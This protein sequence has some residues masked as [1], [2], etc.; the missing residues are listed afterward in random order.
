MTQMLDLLEN[1]AVAEPRPPQKSTLWL[2]DGPCKVF[3]PSDIS[4]CTCADMEKFAEHIS[5]D[6]RGLEMFNVTPKTVF[7][8]PEET[9]RALAHS[10]KGVLLGELRVCPVETGDVLRLKLDEDPGEADKLF[11]AGSLWNWFGHEG[12]A[13]AA[14]SSSELRTDKHKAIWL[15][16]IRDIREALSQAAKGAKRTRGGDH[17]SSLGERAQG[18]WRKGSLHLVEAAPKDEYK[19][20]MTIAPGLEVPEELRSRGAGVDFEYC[21][22]MLKWVGDRLYHHTALRNG[23][24]AEVGQEVLGALQACFL[25][26]A[27]AGIP[28][29]GL[30][31]LVP[32]QRRNAFLGKVEP[33]IVRDIALHQGIDLSPDQEK[34]LSFTHSTESP[35]L[36]IHALAGTGKSTV[37][38][39]IM[40]AY[41]REMP[42]GEAVV[43]LV[44]SRS[45]RDEH[46]MRA[47]IGWGSLLDPNNP[48]LAGDA[49]SALS[50]DACTRI[51]WLGR[52][53]DDTIAE[54][55]DTQAFNMTQKLLAAPLQRL[56][57]RR[58]SQV[59]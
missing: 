15:C 30:N 43:I 22:V 13:E 48:A 31:A 21:G 39:L 38:G 41:M 20:R 4:G 9:V 34:A 47:E 35:V 32:R 17:P 53:A 6:C 27:A 50:E 44:P 51:L 24:G 25:F 23:V 49:G 46:A 56:K 36:V 11:I 45:L 1:K 58:P 33:R 29:Q 7:D 16:P 52:P 2:P 14:Q 3:M 55:W 59:L 10:S 40:E 12:R 18:L 54:E 8:S 37:A 19:W 26:S 28:G 42:P 57:V 5:L